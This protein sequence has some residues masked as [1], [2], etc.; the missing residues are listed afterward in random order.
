MIAHVGVSVVCGVNIKPL[1]RKRPLFAM[2]AEATRSENSSRLAEAATKYGWQMEVP[3]PIEDRLVREIPV[4]A[5][6]RPLQGIRSNGEMQLHST[7]VS[8][9]VPNV[10]TID[11]EF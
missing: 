2:K 11:V 1:N 7:C 3:K 9:F 10:Y 8:L 6:L 5:I 4:A